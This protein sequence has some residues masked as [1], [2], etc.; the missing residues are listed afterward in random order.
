[1]PTLWRVCDHDANILKN[2]IAGAL[3]VIFFCELGMLKYM[4]DAN[5]VSSSGD[6]CNF[7][8]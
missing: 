2:V 6:E 5:A 7:A 8:A 1:M 3:R 4:G